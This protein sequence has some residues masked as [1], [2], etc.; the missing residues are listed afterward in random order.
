MKTFAGKGSVVIAL[1]TESDN[2]VNDA[3]WLKSNGLFGG[4]E[5]TT[6]K[7]DKDAPLEFKFH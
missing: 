6:I 4:E 5:E 2:P 3:K 7:F 1:H